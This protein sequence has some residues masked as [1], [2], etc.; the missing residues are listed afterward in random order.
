M[1]H[2][3]KDH[4]AIIIT[5]PQGCG[6]SI[7]ARTIAYSCGS[8]I[9]VMQSTL[10]HRQFM[11]HDLHE[12]VNTVIVEDVTDELIN[13]DMLQSLICNR[14]IEVDR[15]N[16]KALTMPMPNFILIKKSGEAISMHKHDRRFLII[17]MA[18][19]EP[20][21]IDKDDILSDEDRELTVKIAQRLARMTEANDGMVN[22]I[23]RDLIYEA[24]TNLRND[25]KSLLKTFV[26]A[27]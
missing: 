12:D 14:E 7:L 27:E 17:D 1:K 6:K 25:I 11:F 26:K 4:A 16:Q 24:T 3:F 5:G 19:T 15:P 8:N 23:M 20:G 22:G 21:T 2:L 10:L 9:T 13:S 18:S